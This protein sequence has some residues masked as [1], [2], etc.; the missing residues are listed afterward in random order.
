MSRFAKRSSS[1]GE[2]SYSGFVIWPAAW[3]QYEE[4]G[5]SPDC[6]DRN[7]KSAVRDATPPTEMR[8]WQL[9]DVFHIEQSV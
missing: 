4:G 2:R 8:Q 7:M 9:L 1:K 5:V 3:T 6:S